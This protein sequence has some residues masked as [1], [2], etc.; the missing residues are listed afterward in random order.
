M[1]LVS[2]TGDLAPYYEN[3]SIAAPVAGMRA[4]GFRHLDLSMYTVI[5]PGSPWISPGDGWKKE[6]EDALTLAEKDGL[7]FCQAHSPDGEHFVPGEKRDALITATKRSI[8]ACAML[9]IGHTV[10][11]AAPVPG[12]TQADFLRENVAFYKLFEEEAERFGVDLLTENSAEAW[13]P[14]YYLRTGEEMLAFVRA[15]GIPRLHICWD[16]GHANVQ[17]REQYDDILAMGSELRALHVQ[18]NYGKEDSHLAPLAGTVN[19]DRVLRGLIASGYRGDF[20]FEGG[21]TLRRSGCWPHYRRNVL[22]GDLLS[23]PP[24]HI[25]QKQISVMYEIGVWMLERY[26]IEA[27]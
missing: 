8:E 24:L 27:E 23:E 25:Q 13:N 9:G 18:D 20:T 2:T 5:Y 4:T 6:V 19:F 3:R 7:D 1:K 12:G 11:H 17:G 21:N 15:A 26:G 22:P 10:V 14:E 16:I